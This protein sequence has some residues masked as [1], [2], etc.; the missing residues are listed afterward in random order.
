MNYGPDDFNRKHVFSG[1]F[2]YELPFGRGKR[3]MG[4]AG[5]ALNLIIGGFQLNTTTNWSSGLPWSASYNECSQIRT[6]AFAAH[7]WSGVW[8]R[9]WDTLI[10]SARLEVQ[11]FPS[12]SGGTMPLN[13]DTPGPFQRPQIAQFGSGRNAFTGPSFFN[14]D[15]SLFKNFAITERVGAQFRFEAFNVFN[16]VNLGQPNNCIDC[17]GFRADHRPGAQRADAAVEFR[18]E[19]HLLGNSAPAFPRE[20]LAAPF[21]CILKM[22]MPRS[23]TFSF[24]LLALLASGLLFSSTS[25][26]TNAPWTRLSPDPIISPQGDGWEAAGTF[27]PAVVVHRGKFVMLYRAQDKKGTSRLGYAESSDGIHFSRRS[28]PVLSPEAAYEKD[29]GV[30]DPRLVKFGDTLL[31]DLHRLQQERRAALPRDL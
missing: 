29:G 28:Q 16:H 21:F 3:F 25:H 27:N 9:A 14:S 23:R 30:E 19:G 5:R 24:S 17:S 2:V 10:P 15:M 11:V 31:S 22:A 20:P 26:W 4:N 7:S 13:G 18:N 6:R 1:S 12:Y 8:T